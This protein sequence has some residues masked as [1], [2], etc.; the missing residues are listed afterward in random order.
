MKGSTRPEAEWELGLPVG[1]E[2]SS[3]P[4][5]WL[6]EQGRNIVSARE[7]TTWEGADNSAVLFGGGARQYLDSE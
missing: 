7:V 2:G 3:S 6:E 1:E 4:G 5:C